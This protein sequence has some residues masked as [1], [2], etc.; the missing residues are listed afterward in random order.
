MIIGFD[1]QLISYINLQNGFQ[2]GIGI[3]KLEEVQPLLSSPNDAPDLVV[4]R[5]NTYYIISMRYA[6]SFTNNSYTQI[7][8]ALANNPLYMRIYSNPNFEAYLKT[9]N[10]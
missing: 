3:S 4:L 9:N 6:S 2:K 7:R 5:S 10:P 8:D 1:Q